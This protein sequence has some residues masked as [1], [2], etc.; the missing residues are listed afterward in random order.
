MAFFLPFLVVAESRFGIIGFAML[1]IQVAEWLASR[2]S[3]TQWSLLVPGLLMYLVLSFLFNKLL[4]QS[5]D[6]KS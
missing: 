1:S 3:R 2:P 5:A 6:I 4:L